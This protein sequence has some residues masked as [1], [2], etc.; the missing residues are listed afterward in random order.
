MEC[1]ATYSL[2]VHLAE[3]DAQDRVESAFWARVSG[4]MSNGAA[5]DPYRVE[6]FGEALC[7]IATTDLAVIAGLM[8]LGQ[9]AA[10]GK[11][12]D[13]HIY[14]HVESLAVSQAEAMVENC[15]FCYGAGCYHCE[16]P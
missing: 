7:Q 1:A 13:Q 6:Q 15:R 16:G 4:L 3:Q 10:A 14:R 9:H 5:F 12:L 2:N 11:L 8:R